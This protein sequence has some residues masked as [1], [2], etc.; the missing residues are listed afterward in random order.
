M[1]LGIGKLL[2]FFATLWG[3]YQHQQMY[4]IRRRTL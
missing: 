4:I 3:V 1:V 2:Y